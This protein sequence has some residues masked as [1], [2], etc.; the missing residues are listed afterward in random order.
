MPPGFKNVKSLV[1]PWLRPHG[2]VGLTVVV[3]ERGTNPIVPPKQEGTSSTGQGI[4]ETDVRQLLKTSRE[5]KDLGSVREGWILC[6]DFRK[7][8]HTW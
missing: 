1:A 5:A 3:E 7:T 4:R 2:W 6:E 8:H